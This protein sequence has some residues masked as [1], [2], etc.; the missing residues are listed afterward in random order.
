MSRI[1]SVWLPRWPIKRFLM[2]QAISPAGKPIDPERP[3][4]LAI[5]AT[6]GLRIAAMNETAE[7]AGIVAGDPVADARAKADSLQ[8]R[9]ADST[10]DDAALHRLALWATR[11]TPTASPWIEE[12]GADGFFLD[13]EGAAHLFGGEENLLADLAGRLDRFGLPARL[14]IADTTGMAWALSHFDAAAQSILPAGREAE[15]LSAKPIEALRLSGETR[16]LLRRLGFKSVGALLDKPRAPFAARFSDELLCRLDQA[17]GRREEP[18]IPVTA[19]PVYHSLNYLLE[20][21]VNQQAILARACRLMQ[22]LT[23]V[24][25]RDAVGARALRLSLYGV[26]GAVETIDI[27]LT[28]PTR[29]VPHIARLIDLRLEMLAAMHDGGLGFEAIGLAVTHVESMPERQTELNIDR[30]PEVQAQRTSK[31]DNSNGVLRGPR[32]ARA[33]QD[34]DS[35]KGAAL[36]DAMRQRLGPDRVRQFEIVPSH[37]PECAETLT[38]INGETPQYPRLARSDPPLSGEGCWSI[39]EKPR[40]LLLLPQAE[41]TEV[42]ALIPEGPPRRFRWHGVTYDIT[43][44]Q[45]PERIADEWWRA[46]Y[47]S[48][49][50]APT[51]DYY[52][53]EDGEGHRFWL[54]REGLYG[55]ETAT[56]RWFVHGL[57]A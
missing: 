20:P 42:T 37:I 35:E 32:S 6:G 27:G 44:A 14:A 38:E 21:I 24:L 25:V 43:G 50:G 11:Y 54:Y 9:A 30:Y 52:L 13:I 16:A 5:P 55:R 18:L 34:D 12:N 3:F 26:D 48:R 17:L 7:D 23:H 1:V 53:V 47:P 57:F 45:G 28:S 46:P 19:P 49:A 4:V 39:E 2:A 15:A 56:P 31:G 40:P 41:P 51:R 33:P 36:I 10:A 22:H 29:S 8:V